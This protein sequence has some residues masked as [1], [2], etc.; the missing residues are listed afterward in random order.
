MESQP[1]N[2][3]FRI[4]PENFQPCRDY[5]NNCKTLKFGASKY[6]RFSWKNLLVDFNLDK[7]SIKKCGASK[8]WRFSWVDLSS[9]LLIWWIFYFKKSAVSDVAPCILCQF[10]TV[11]SDFNMFSIQHCKWVSANKIVCLEVCHFPFIWL[12]YP[13]YCTNR[14]AVIPLHAR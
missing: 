10:Y 1:Q 4:D 2:P 13:Y 3:E 6:W 11:T 8:F 12:V 5:Y 7:F 14:P 9:G